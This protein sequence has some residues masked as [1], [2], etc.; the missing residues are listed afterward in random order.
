[1]PVDQR[2]QDRRP[3][4]AGAAPRKRL[5]YRHSV[6]VRV[7]HW[8][9][10]VVI[11]IMLMSGL[12]IFNAHPALD[13]GDHSFDQ[14]LVLFQGKM[15]DGKPVGTTRIFGH[16][17]DTTGWFGV[18]Y[19]DGQ[20]AARAFPPW[21]TIPSHRWLAMG[22]RW[23]FFFAWLFVLNG[24]AYL[25]YS[26]LSRHFWRD[27]VPSWRGLK[28]IGGDIVDHLKFHFPANERG[29]YNV[30]QRLTYLFVI[31]LGLLIVAT[32]LT[33]SPTLDVAMPW[34]LHIFGGRQTARTLHFVAAFAFL[35]FFIVHIALVLASGV[36]NNLRAMITGHFVARTAGDR[37]EP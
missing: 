37:D 7:T 27:L 3:A 26:L 30:L 6:P 13:W 17:F 20:P 1:M 14:P 35:G 36:F 11:T 29:R 21:A 2:D 32:G 16:E 23:H 15:V 25:L 28:H 5:I 9:N 33:M 24:F 22:R 31:G 12:Q 10:F 34:L 4:A 19:V 8:I 18:S